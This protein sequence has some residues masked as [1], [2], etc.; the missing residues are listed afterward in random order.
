MGLEIGRT[1]RRQTNQQR[2]NRLGI[3]VRVPERTA[4]AISRTQLARR[5]QQATNRGTIN[6]PT[7]GRQTSGRRIISQRT[8]SLRLI[9]LQMTVLMGPRI[10]QPRVIVRRAVHRGT[11]LCPRSLNRP[12]PIVPG[13]IHLHQ[14]AQTKIGPSKIQHRKIGPT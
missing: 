7:S 14:I 5:I 2:I 13:R 3:N 1:I 8:T 4:P 11:A 12:T 10:G 6:L 9:D